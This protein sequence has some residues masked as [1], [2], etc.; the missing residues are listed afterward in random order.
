MKKIIIGFYFAALFWCSVG[1]ASS[2]GAKSV[3]SSSAIKPTLIGAINTND[4]SSSIYMP[5][6]IYDAFLLREPKPLL[7]A[8]N[9][10]QSMVRQYICTA[11]V[12]NIAQQ[13]KVVLQKPFGPK[14]VVISTVIIKLNKG[15]V[16]VIPENYFSMLDLPIISFANSWDWR[17]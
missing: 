7:I 9:K 11:D 1:S 17:C 6:F 5:D 13:I 2:G 14:S 8:L 12:M 4:Q 16:F 10:V 3:A 15:A